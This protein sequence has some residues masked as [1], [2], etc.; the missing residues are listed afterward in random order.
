MT[1]LS[2]KHGLISTEDENADDERRY[3]DYYPGDQRN[4]RPT[5]QPILP[6]RVRSQPG[7]SRP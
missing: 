7:R 2:A 3:S 4:A 6:G 5:P 1:P